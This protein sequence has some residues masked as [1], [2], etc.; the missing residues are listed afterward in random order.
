MSIYATALLD[1][2]D[3]EDMSYGEAIMLH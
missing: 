3:D 2:I 1:Y